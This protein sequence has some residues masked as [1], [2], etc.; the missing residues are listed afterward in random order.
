M[1]C[2]ELTMTYIGGPTALLEVA[3]LRLLTDPTLDPAGGTYTAGPVT[4]RKLA[5]PAVSPDALGRIDLV[6]LSHDHHFDNLDHLGRALLPRAGRVLTTP[7]GADRLGG[8]AVGLAPWQRRDLPT[9]DGRVLRVT[10]TPARHGPAGGDRGPATGFALAVGGGAE[11]AV[12]V[13][14]DTVWYDGV[15]EVARRFRIGTAVLFMGAARVREVGPHHV[16]MTAE[17]GIEVARL[18]SEATIVPLHFEGWAHLSESQETIGRA[19]A[20]AGLDARLRWLEPGVP[21]VLRR[22]ITRPA[23][24]AHAFRL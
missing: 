22:Q 19:F 17:E 3:G 9:P 18:F 24:A 5:G 14:G 2:D 8:N 20:A 1:K 12:Y 23:D 4:L 21:T 13:S 11:D 10:A 16:T 15:A 6:L 7:S